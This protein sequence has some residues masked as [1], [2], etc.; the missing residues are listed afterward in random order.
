MSIK[1]GPTGKYLQNNVYEYLKTQITLL[2][3]YILED[4]VKKIIQKYIPSNQYY[5]TWRDFAIHRLDPDLLENIKETVTKNII[6]LCNY[7]Y[8]M[9]DK[10]PSWT[11]LLVKDI[12]DFY[13]DVH[14]N[15]L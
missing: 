11:G 4:A 3:E 9:E 5:G 12:T 13:Q 14:I 2:N 7:K 6:K 15:R 8:Y 10:R 1:D